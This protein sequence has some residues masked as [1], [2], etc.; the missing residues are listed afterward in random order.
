MKCKQCKEKLVY[1][2]TTKG[3]KVFW[4]EPCQRECVCKIGEKPKSI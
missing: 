2:L 3:K 1:C 4:C